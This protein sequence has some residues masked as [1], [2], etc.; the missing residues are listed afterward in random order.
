MDDCNGTWPSELPMRGAEYTE[1]II[2]SL[3][4]LL[5]PFLSFVSSL[6]FAHPPFERTVIGK[7]HWKEAVVVCDFLGFHEMS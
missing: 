1:P 5:L 2:T 6:S 4:W 7:R 3:A